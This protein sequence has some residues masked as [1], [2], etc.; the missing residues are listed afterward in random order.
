MKH[1]V[2]NAIDIMNMG[3][4]KSSNGNNLRW[5]PCFYQEPTQRADDAI[6]TS[7]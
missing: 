4:T 7:S 6:M 2:I 5:C 3:K 1:V